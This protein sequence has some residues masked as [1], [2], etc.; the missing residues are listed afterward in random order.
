MSKIIEKKNLRE[1]IRFSKKWWYTEDDN[2]NVYNQLYEARRK[3]FG[4]PHTRLNDLVMSIVSL[5][6]KTLL[7]TYYKVFEALGYELS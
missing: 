7:S 5:D 4:T 3:A 2:D 1:V 6:K